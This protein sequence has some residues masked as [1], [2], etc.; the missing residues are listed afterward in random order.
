MKVDLWHRVA[1]VELASPIRIKLRK[2]VLAKSGS[3]ARTEG[4]DSKQ[5]WEKEFPRGHD[6]QGS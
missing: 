3:S 5:S 6:S 1:G 2:L 4:C